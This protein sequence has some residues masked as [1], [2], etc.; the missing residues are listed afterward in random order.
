MNRALPG[1]LPR[2]AESKNEYSGSLGFSAGMPGLFSAYMPGEEKT[3]ICAAV[4][5]LGNLSNMPPF[6]RKD[7]GRE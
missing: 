2:F 4:L 3:G 1:P 6:L 5:L 7:L